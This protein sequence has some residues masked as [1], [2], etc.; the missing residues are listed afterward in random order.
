MQALCS[1]IDAH[2]DGYNVIKL[3]EIVPPHTRSAVPLFDETDVEENEDP[4]TN[5][6]KVPNS[7]YRTIIRIE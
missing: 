2:N 5:T 3:W 6:G 1:S 7:I 4:K